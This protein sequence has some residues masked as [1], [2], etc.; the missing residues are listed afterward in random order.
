MI[1]RKI[2][3]GSNSGIEMGDDAETQSSQHLGVRTEGPHR[4]IDASLAAPTPSSYRT[5]TDNSLPV[6]RRT[7]KDSVR[8]R[9]AE[10]RAVDWP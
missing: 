7:A 1:L 5:C 2:S 6:S 9:P 3:A 10:F 8:Y 4:R